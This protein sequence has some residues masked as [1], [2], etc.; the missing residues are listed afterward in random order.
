MLVAANHFPCRTSIQCLLERLE[1]VLNPAI[2]AQA[3]AHQRQAAVLAAEI[4]Y[5]HA[6][7]FRFLLGAAA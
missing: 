7:L 6:P 4:G 2:R 5:Q 1:R 3:E